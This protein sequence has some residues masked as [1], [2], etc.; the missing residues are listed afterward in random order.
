MKLK[1]IF[2][3]SSI[4]LTCLTSTTAAAIDLGALVKSTPEELKAAATDAVVSSQ[5]DQVIDYAAKQLG[6]SATTVKASFGSIL[7][8]AQSNLSEDNFALIS[9]AVPD[10]EQYLDKAPKIDTSSVT[11]SFT[12]LFSSDEENKADENKNYLT[13]AFESL[14]LS[15]EQI[16]TVVDTLSGYMKS[17]GYGDA[18]NMLEKGLS[19]L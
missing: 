10:V 17:S 1:T 15:S 7:K 8:V 6:V 18:A 5:A 2:L 9:K 11:S 3:A 19:F 13:S 16:P 4:A 12:S 14:G